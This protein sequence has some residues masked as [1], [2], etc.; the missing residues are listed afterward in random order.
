MK[1]V[2]S[3]VILSSRTK[4][5]TVD[6]APLYDTTPAFV[7]LLCAKHTQT[8]P[9]WLL[10]ACHRGSFNPRPVSVRFGW[11][12]AAPLIAHILFMYNNVYALLFFFFFSFLRRLILCKMAA[13]IPFE[14]MEEKFCRVDKAGKQHFRDIKEKG[15]LTNGDSSQVCPQWCVLSCTWFIQIF[16]IILAFSLWS[17]SA[18]VN[19]HFWMSAFRGNLPRLTT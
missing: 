16:L 10:T 1:Q 18:L 12:A 17:K 4:S 11:H 2:I 19:V 8:A 5:R 13:H 9:R 15:T 3:G 6:R 14:D 7:A